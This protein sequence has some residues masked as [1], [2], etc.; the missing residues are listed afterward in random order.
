MAW[1]NEGEKMNS[2][3]SIFHKSGS[4]LGEGVMN[5][6]LV[7][8]ISVAMMWVG[9]SQATTRYVVPPG[10][11]HAPLSP[12]TNWVD[13]A[14]NLHDVMAV[15]V[16][17]DTVLVT[18]GVYTLTDQ[19]SIA[20]NITIR[21]ENN[22]AND[23][24]NTII[25]GDNYAG[26][27]VTNRCFSLSHSNAVVEGFTITN[28]FAMGDGGGVNITSSGGTLRNCLVIGNTSSN[29][30]GGGVYATGTKSMV[31]NCD[32]IANA[33]KLAAGT[34]STGGGGVMLVS[35]AQAW[36]SR[37]MYNQSPLN[38]SCGGGV[39]LSSGGSLIN[40]TIMN[41]TNLAGYGGGGVWVIGAG[42][43]LRNCLITGNNKGAG[44]TG[45]GV[46]TH[47]GGAVIENCT[48]VGNS[49]DGIGAS[50]WPCTYN[51][52]NTIAYYNALADMTTSTGGGTLVASNCCMSSTGKVT[53]GS[54]NITGAPAFMQRASGDY[55]LAP[56]SR[57]VDAGLTLSW[58]STATDLAGNPRISTLPDMG[59]YE[60]A[61]GPVA[62]YYVARNGQTPVSPYTNG[63]AA[64][65]SNIL[66]AVSIMS[67]GATILV[68]NGV[69]T[70]TNQITVSFATLRSFNNDGV[71]RGTIINGNYPNTTNRC[72]FIN[73]A[74]AL[75]EG[76][77]ITNGC[78]PSND[79][80]GG[81]VYITNGILRNCLVTGN[82]ATNNPT[83]NRGGGVYA[84]GNSVITNCDITA[85]MI[86]YTGS[87]GGIYLATPAQLWASRIHQNGTPTTNSITGSS[88]G[89]VYITGT[90]A[91]I[92]NSIITSNVLPP[93]ANSANGGGVYMNNGGTLRNCL[94]SGNSAF[95]GAGV[96]VVGSLVSDLENCT[97]AG[98]TS[99][100]NG[101]LAI[102]S[103]AYLQA[104]LRNVICYSNQPNNLYFNNLTNA[105]FTNCCVVSS[106]T[107]LGSGNIATNPLFVNLA[108]A[109]Y[110][111]TKASPCINAGIYQTWMTGALD[112]DGKLRI[113]PKVG[114]TVDMGAYE[115]EIQSS[116]SM[117][118]IE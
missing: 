78:A 80:F 74:E 30:S 114:G 79:C 32:V 47:G 3:F 50:G 77:T 100:Y 54:V 110:R 63:W 66:D 7:V 69:Y 87:G 98:N 101:G 43:T 94:I 49:G 65:A 96:A 25:S 106:Y 23:I 86:W 105:V 56:W 70:L 11:G 92:C 28:G 35:G 93:G 76:F 62:T 83:G 1:K 52:V 91:L 6:Q 51:C 117:I 9:A 71:D 59:A 13:A 67:D 118:L 64:A 29:G 40:C 2:M 99:G 31:T 4:R 41:N 82:L 12:Y 102:P 103:Y 38:N 104:R 17:G 84:T 34:T 22:G 61:S 57:G 44:V 75:V 55:R 116:G 112:L 26:K 60:T 115:Y 14:T 5:T 88:G 109:N 68:T 97:I 89:G 27:P 21:S 111:L 24:L 33:A 15:T 19:I 45:A 37:I 85:N 20:A 16:G 90:N 42:N 10:G 39:F 113:S 18:N 81:G 48:I 72:L 108:G 8:F 73:H 107:L 58:M 95:A 53:S 46:G 36:N